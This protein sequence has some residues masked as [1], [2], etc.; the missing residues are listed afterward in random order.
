[1]RDFLGNNGNVWAKFMHDENMLKDGMWLDDICEIAVGKIAE[2]DQQ[3]RWL[4]DD[5]FWEDFAH[6]AEDLGYKLK[7]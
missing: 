7:Y 4:K 3:K 6:R 1:M 5:G 2:T